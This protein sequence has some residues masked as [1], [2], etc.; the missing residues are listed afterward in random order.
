[1]SARIRLGV[2]DHHPLFRAGVT[3]TLAMA[4]DCDVVAEGAGQGDALRIAAEHAPNVLLLDLHADFSVEAVRR[5]ATEFPAMRTM[6]FTVV[7]DED[8]VVA[9]LRA[10]A[11]GYMLKG[12]SGAELVESIRRVHRGEFYVFPS[13][14]AALLGTTLRREVKPDRFSTL[15]L[16]EEQVL[17]CLTRGLSNKE[18]ARQLA[19]AE[20]TVKHYVSEL[21]DK[22][23][24]RNRVEAAILGQGR[25]RQDA[26]RDAP[27]QQSPATGRK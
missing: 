14:A 16:R 7:A 24:V 18:I 27:L 13:L 10:G 23:E 12:A 15:T 4:G 17:D 8:Q 1:M 25:P 2:V 22:L 21:F 20:K 6:I 9:A 5:L 19:L 26:R 3:Y 11:A